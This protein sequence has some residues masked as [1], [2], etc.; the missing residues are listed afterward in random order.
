MTFPRANPLGWALFELLTSDQMNVID[1]NV[2]FALDGRDGG[3]YAA[4]APIVLL[5]TNNDTAHLLRLEGAS[6]AVASEGIPVLRVIGQ[7]NSLWDAG[8]AVYVTGGQTSVNAGNRFAGIGIYAQG[9]TKGGLVQRGGPGIFAVGGE[10]ILQASDV[11]GTNGG[12]AFK[13]I[14]GL[15]TGNLATHYGQTAVLGLGGEILV[16]GAAGGIGVHGIG[17]AGVSADY[18]ADDN[19]IGVR[20]VG[21]VG[22]HGLASLALVDQS[23]DDNYTTNVTVGVRASSKDF[24]LSFL[25]EHLD[26]SQSGIINWFRWAGDAGATTNKTMVQISAEM[27]PGPAGTLFTTGLS[28]S[29]NITAR[30]F[31][32]ASIGGAGAEALTLSVSAIDTETFAPL[33]LTGVTNG[34]TELTTGGLQVYNRRV[35]IGLLED[36]LFYGHGP[37]GLLYDRVVTSAD[38]ASAWAWCRVLCDGTPLGQFL[39]ASY[40]VDTAIA[41]GGTSLR[42]TLTNNLAGGNPATFEDLCVHVTIGNPGGGTV[43]IP[44]ADVL[45]PDEIAVSMRTAGGADVSFDTVDVIVYVV[46]YARSSWGTPADRPTF[47]RP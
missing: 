30:R 25:S 18:L 19:G 17:G 1:E 11:A 23:L 7:N 47:Y 31:K 12:E 13:A 2:S 8:S 4:S 40:N 15:T 5:G 26:D 29:S 3:S 6:I 22:V 41:V 44:Y 39:Q 34:V 14:G 32:G 10:G 21:T 16:A 37:N 24:G 33:K 36:S 27:D 45:G 42:I 38:Q 28:I 46:V 9:G 43:W 35:G 20:G